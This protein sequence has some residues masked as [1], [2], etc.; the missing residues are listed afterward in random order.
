MR[1]HHAD[2]QDGDKAINL[3]DGPKS[4]WD[5]GFVLASSQV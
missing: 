2:A 4:E 3:R 1:L 5:F